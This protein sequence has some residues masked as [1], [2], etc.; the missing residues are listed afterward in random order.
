MQFAFYFAYLHQNRDKL[1]ALMFSNEFMACDSAAARQALIDQHIDR[2]EQLSWEKLVDPVPP[3]A[4]KSRRQFDDWLRSHMWRDFEHALPGQSR[5]P[6]EIGLRRAARRARRGARRDRL[7]RPVRALAPLGAVRI[8]ADHEPAGGG[9]A[10][11][12]HRAIAGADG[13]RHG[14][15]R[16]R[17]GR[18]LRPRRRQRHLRRAKP[19]AGRGGDARMCWCAGAP[20]CP[21]R[22]KT[23]RR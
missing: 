7:R 23:S 19:L 5:Q 1:T 10:E 22:W 16:L 8:F 18:Q 2:R 21:G 12:A 4:L 6:A 3:L 20:R 17:A 15:R 13:C 11:R 14:A 9:P